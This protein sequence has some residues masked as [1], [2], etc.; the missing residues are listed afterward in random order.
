[1]SRSDENTL[2]EWVGVMRIHLKNERKSWFRQ[3]FDRCLTNLTEQE[4]CIGNSSKTMPPTETHRGSPWIHSSLNLDV[5]TMILQ[6]SLCRWECYKN[7]ESDAQ[8]RDLTTSILLCTPEMI[9]AHDELSVLRVLGWLRS[10]QLEWCN[11]RYGVFLW[12]AFILKVIYDG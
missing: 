1:M 2:E 10:I 6:S 12:F 3:R 5:I 8:P 4:N 7:L 9:L 11:Q